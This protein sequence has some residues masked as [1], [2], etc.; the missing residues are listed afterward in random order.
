M[1]ED[2]IPSMM[3]HPASSEEVIKIVEALR[4]RYPKLHDAG[5]PLDLMAEARNGYCPGWF[6]VSD[7][8]NLDFYIY[9]GSG[10]VIESEVDYRY[11]RG[12]LTKVHFFDY[13]VIT[14]TDFLAGRVTDTGKVRH[15][16]A[17]MIEWFMS[18]TDNHVEFQPEGSSGWFTASAP[19]WRTTSQ[20]RKVI[21][22]NKARPQRDV[23]VAWANDQSLTLQVMQR[24]GWVDINNGDTI[25]VDC[26]ALR[27][28]TKELTELE[29]QAESILANPELMEL[30]KRQM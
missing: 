8:A 28:T 30:I 11:E 4:N 12:E 25:N 6:T 3:F 5:T 17:D 13:P 10:N 2:I 16:H 27:T 18:S 14:I 7:D 29:K 22:T 1:N 9:Y 20:Y 26:T 24:D 15:I 19:N 23:M 21:N